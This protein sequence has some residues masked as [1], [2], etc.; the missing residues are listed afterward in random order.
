MARA[1]MGKQVGDVVRVGNS[2]SQV[3]GINP[4]S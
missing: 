4:S 3:L 2:V 1:L